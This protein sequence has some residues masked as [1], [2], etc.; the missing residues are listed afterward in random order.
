MVSEAD[1][2]KEVKRDLRKRFRGCIVLKNDTSHQQGFPDLMVLYKDK[3]AALECKRSATEKQQ[4]NQKHYIDTLNNMSYAAFICPEN[5]EEI[6]DAI[7]Q[8]FKP[9]R[10][11][12][13]FES[14]QASLD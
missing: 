13:I 9:R 4:P 11:S 3:W 2:Q 8:T 6:F 10:T 12:R 14:K 1:F 7:Q 5:K